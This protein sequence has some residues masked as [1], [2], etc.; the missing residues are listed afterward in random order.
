MPILDITLSTPLPSA[1]IRLRIA[2]SGVTS[3]ERRRCATRSSTRLH[4]EVRVDRGGAV[5]DEQRDVVHL[6]HVAGLDEQRDRG[7]AAWSA[8]QVVVH[9]RGEQQRRD[10]RVVGVGVA[11]GQHD[12]PRARRDRG[13]DLRA[14]L[15]PAAAPAPSPPPCTAVQPADLQAARNPGRSPS[16]LMCR[17][18]ASSSLSMTGNGSTTWRQDAGPGVEQVALRADQRAQRRDELLADRVQ[19]RVGDLREQLA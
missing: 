2:C 1:L 5:A 17:I 7:C 12:E 9:G 8:D 4:R 10:R 19:R 13:G 15:A 3:V 6:A 16:A 11:V 14:D 18:L